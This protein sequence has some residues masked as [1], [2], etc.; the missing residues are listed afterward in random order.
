MKYFHHQRLKGQPASMHLKEWLQEPLYFVSGIDTDAGKTVVTGFLSRELLEDGVQA[1]TQKFIQTG[2]TDLSED[3]VEHR[4]VEGRDLL[5]ED[6]DG[7]TC[8]LVYSYPCS[9]HMAAQIDGKPLD[10]SKVEESTKL[11]LKKSDTLFLEGAGGLMVPLSEDYLTID[12]VEQHQIPTILVVTAKLGSINHAV[13]SLEVLKKRGIRCPLVV[14]NR[15]IATDDKITEET[16]RW[17][18]TYLGN[19]FPDTLWIEIGADMLREV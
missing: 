13:L 4:K 16:A 6:L 14:Y 8:P 9:P 2:V 17:L 18:S 10:V 5:P 7:T 3:I 15:H 11:L 1:L 12:Y 19:H